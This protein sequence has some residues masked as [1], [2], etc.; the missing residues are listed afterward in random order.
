MKKFLSF[1]VI[2]TFCMVATVCAALIDDA[3]SWAYNQG[4][5][6]YRTSANFYP[7]NVLRRDEAAKFYVNFAEFLGK[8]TYTVEASACN[9]FTDLHKA[10]NDL[11]PYITASCRMGIFKGDNGK[12]LPTNSLTN[13]QAVTVLMRIIDGN[14]SES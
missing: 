8:T 3:I 4:L 6:K 1:L 11:L 13:A 7:H 2:G 9:S 14:Q 10:H 5:T 12:F